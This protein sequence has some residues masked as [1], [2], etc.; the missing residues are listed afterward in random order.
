MGT[1]IDLPD[2]MIRQVTGRH[3][4]PLPVARKATGQPL[5][6]LSNEEIERILHEEEVAGGPQA[7]SPL[8]VLIP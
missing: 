2:E 6:S 8:L 5:L 7:A 1:T 3:R 4:S